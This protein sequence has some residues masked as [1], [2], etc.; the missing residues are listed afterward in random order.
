MYLGAKIGILGGNGG[1][2]TSRIQLTHG[3]KP[4]GFNPRSYQVDILVSNFAFQQMQLV[5]LP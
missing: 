2:C 4:P 1:G 5:H 3:L